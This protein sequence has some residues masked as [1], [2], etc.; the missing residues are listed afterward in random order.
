MSFV[1]WKMGV[2]CIDSPN[3][4]ALMSAGGTCLSVPKISGSKEA[5]RRKPVEGSRSK[6]AVCGHT[7]AVIAYGDFAA[8]L[9]D[10]ISRRYG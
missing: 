5:G 8:A 2:E 4:A 10:W 1:S 7:I 9:L 6:E 3:D